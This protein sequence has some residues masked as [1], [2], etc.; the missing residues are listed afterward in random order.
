MHKIF[1]R[2]TFVFLVFTVAL[3][4]VKVLDINFQVRANPPEKV[5]IC[6]ASSSQ[7]NPY[8]QEEPNKSADVSG[9]DGHT[10]PVWFSGITVSWGDIIPPFTYTGGSYP[11]K[12]WTT[13]GQA[14]FNNGCAI[15][16]SCDAEEDCPSSCHVDTVEVADGN[17]GVKQCLGNAPA[18]EQCPDEC[19]VL[20]T[21]VSDGQ[22][23]TKE[24]AINAPRAQSCPDECG[25]D[26]GT[27]P[28]G[29]CGYTEC[30]ATEECEGEPTPTPTPT[31]VPEQD[32]TST[33]TPTPTATPT[34]Q[35]TGINLGYNI[36][37][38][39]DGFE[40]TADVRNGGSPVKDIEVY[41]TYGPAKA[42]SKTNADGRATTSFTKAGDGK[43]TA[44]ASG[45]DKVSIDVRIPTDCEAAPGTG[46][47][48]LGASTD[49]TPTQSSGQVL[50]AST[51]P[52]TFADTGLGSLWL[53]LVGLA[54][55][56]YSFSR[57]VKASKI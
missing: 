22:C 20:A 29:E 8:V 12:N 57:V 37:C 7:T 48:V 50:G 18:E 42:T 5:T 30:S 23:G 51:D 49:S 41:F 35:E 28:D 19:R 16:Q 2:L 4:W 55:L 31:N 3:S 24:C 25:Y 45:Y 32:L 39:G 10:G 26:G 56:G 46:G 54:A 27:V 6:H 9:H 36:G 11:G 43:L 34:P 52:E 1:H 47:V 15:P 40:V 33:P 38:N 14:I 17:C 21:Y 44:E 53:S 13:E